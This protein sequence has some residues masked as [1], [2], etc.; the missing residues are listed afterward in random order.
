MLSL[1]HVYPR[2]ALTADKWRSAQMLSL[3]SDST[4]IINVAQIDT[5]SGRSLKTN[6]VV[7]VVQ[8]YLYY[9]GLLQMACEYLSLIV[10]ERWIICKTRNIALIFVPS[11][12]P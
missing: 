1:Q 2:R 5:V 10:L 6:I 3:L 7:V 11:M 12:E 4:K 9:F 8:L